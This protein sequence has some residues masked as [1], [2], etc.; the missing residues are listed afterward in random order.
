MS[1][2]ADLAAFLKPYAEKPVEWG[3]DDCT[4]VCAKWLWQNGH[5]F[6]LPVYSSKREAQAIIVQHGGLVET[7]DALLPLSIGGRLGGPEIG[8]IGVIDTLLHGPVGVIIGQGGVCLWREE[9]RGF[10]FIKPRNFLKVW[11]VEPQ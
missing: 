7:W 9:H 2:A 6:D 10:H 3:V 8:D 1:R 11:A 5:P 4:A